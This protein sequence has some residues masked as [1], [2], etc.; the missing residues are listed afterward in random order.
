[1]RHGLH[2][3]LVQVQAGGDEA[4]AVSGGAGACYPRAF[5]QLALNLLDD[6]D[7][8]RQRAAFV[9]GVRRPY[10]F[11]VVVDERRFDGG[12]SGVDA[13][14]VR[15]LRAFQRADVHMLAVVALVERLTVRF[16]REQRR[17]GGGV[18]RQIL[19]IFKAFQNI[20]A[21]AC[22]EMLA[23]LKLVGLAG[24]QRGAERH[25]QVR[26]GRHDEFVDFA[27]ERAVERLA[28]FGHEEQRA[29]QEDD[30]AVDWSAGRQTCD[31]LRGDRREDGC[32]QIG[33]GRAVVDERLKIGF[34]E[35]AATGGD[36]IERLVMLGHVVEASRVGVEQGGHLVDERAGAACAG[37]VH[38]LFRSRLQICD[39]GVLTAK[40]DNDVGLRIFLV[41]GAGLGDD[42]LH[43]RHMEIIGQGKAAG[44]GDGQTNR[45]VAAATGL[46]FFVDVL[47]Q[48]R[49]GGTHVGVVATVIGEEHRV[50]RIGLIEHHGLHRGGTDVKTYAQRLRIAGV[51]CGNCCFDHVL[52]LYRSH[53]PGCVR[54]DTN[55]LPRLSKYV[56]VVCAPA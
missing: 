15:T 1:M 39:L 42:L 48:A 47:Q 50:E 40:F 14:E 35:H 12:R 54:A 34:G 49:H 18:R 46:K 19:Q 24:E 20:G 27:F 23:F 55:A 11:A 22:F 9:G 2:H 25:V 30:G 36:R 52:Y 7:S 32:G 43:E 53:P 21:G 41:D 33:L 4:F 16:G 31:G 10:D 5:R 6:V 8:G 29:A 3:A 26:V 13:E 45:L 44:T 28:Q 51:V 38:A 17:H 56:M 37:T